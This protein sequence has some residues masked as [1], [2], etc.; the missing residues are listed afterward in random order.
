MFSLQKESEML[1][2]KIIGKSNVKKK[3]KKE[4][5]HENKE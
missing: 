1:K 5:K 4:R 3:H 2:A